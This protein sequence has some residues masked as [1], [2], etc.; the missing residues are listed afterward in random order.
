MHKDIKGPINGNESTDAE[1]TMRT[2]PIMNGDDRIVVALYNL[3]LS[4]RAGWG[5]PY[6]RVRKSTPP[7]QLF[8]ALGVT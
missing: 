2:L 3:S 7:T 1:T 6:R 5:L 4:S 8:G